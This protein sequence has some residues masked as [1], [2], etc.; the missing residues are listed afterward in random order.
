LDESDSAQQDVGPS[1]RRIL[2]DTKLPRAGSPCLGFEQRHLPTSAPIDAARDTL[3]GDQ[4]RFFHAIHRAAMRAL[5]P[6]CFDT[7]GGRRRA[8]VLPVK[9]EGEYFATDTR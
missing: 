6:D 7:S 5:D 4:R 1:K 8:S 2:V 3:A 9:Q